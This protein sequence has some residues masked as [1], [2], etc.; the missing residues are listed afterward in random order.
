M[1]YE[2]DDEEADRIYEAVDAKIDERRK[3][4]REARE[5]EEEETF[6]ASRPTIQAQFADLKRGLA[7]MTD[8]EWGSLRTLRSLAAHRPS[9]VLTLCLSSQPK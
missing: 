8:D 4:R 3:S 1:V 7:D 2:A 5:K 6:R 9:P